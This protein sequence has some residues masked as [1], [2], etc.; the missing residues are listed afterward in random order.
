MIF[1]E[2][3]MTFRKRIEERGLSIC[4]V[5]LGTIGL[6]VS[7]LFAK[8][9]FKVTGYD[10]D[11]ERVVMINRGEVTFEYTAWL[12]ESIKK[13]TFEATTDPAKGLRHAEITIVCV[14]T[15][16]TSKKEMDESHLASATGAIS[17]N[18][19][20]GS[21]TVFES[22]LAPGTAKKLGELMREQSGLVPGIDFG[23][24]CC[25]ERYSPSLPVETHPQTLYEENSAYSPRLTLDRIPRIVGGIDPKS[26]RIARVLYESVIAAGVLE[27]SSLEVAEAAKAVEN[28]YRDVNIALANELAKVL[29]LIGVDA[30]E[31]INAAKTKPFA[32]MAHYP[33]PGVGGECIPVVPWFLIKAAESHGVDARLMKAAREINDSMPAY[34]VDTLAQMLTRAGRSLA[35]STIGILG[36]AYKKNASDTRL[37]PALEV[38][39]MLESQGAFVRCSDPLVES[40]RD[41]LDLYAPE[42]VC[43]GAD[44]VLILADHD[45][46]RGIELGLLKSKMRTPIII[47]C[48]NLYA[49]I[50]KPSMQHA[51]SHRTEDHWSMKR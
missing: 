25:P 9:G 48:R 29:P 13:R 14:P 6:P 30:L 26:A 21:V 8:N 49:G 33:G 27:V 12:R 42:A 24:A 16:T 35:G 11:D 17:Q 19:Q 43:G 18:M 23:L 32:F 37:S 51:R 34:V 4:T 2:D 20:R 50:G 3:E 10:V 40:N 1:F 39:H 46:F 15:P 44:A 5:G 31:A 36:I 45:I 7:V 22:S 41:D 28:T 47:D 38:L